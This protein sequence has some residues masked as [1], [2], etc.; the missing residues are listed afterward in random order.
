MDYDRLLTMTNSLGQEESVLITYA[1]AVTLA[2]LV[3]SGAVWCEDVVD[4]AALPLAHG[5]A[6]SRWC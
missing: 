4:G 5:P 2:D 1:V 3:G 6:R